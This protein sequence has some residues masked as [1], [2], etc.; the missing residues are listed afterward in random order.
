M[1]IHHLRLEALRYPP[2][3]FTRHGALAHPARPPLPKRPLT[4]GSLNA[5]SLTRI[6]LIGKENP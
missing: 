5:P 4:T 3:A 2:S 6:Q 1:R